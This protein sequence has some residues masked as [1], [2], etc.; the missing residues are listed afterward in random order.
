MPKTF[1]R[2]ASCISN[3]PCPACPRRSGANLR[4]RIEGIMSIR[5][6]V[7]RS[8]T[9]KATLEIAAIPAV[10]APNIVGIMNAPVS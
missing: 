4:K 2:F 1:S 3:H 9:R 6:G 7:G 5:I 8:I 10:A